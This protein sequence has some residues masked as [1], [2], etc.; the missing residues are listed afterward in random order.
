LEEKR[1]PNRWE[2]DAV[3]PDHPVFVP[4]GGHVC[5]VNSLPLDMANIS[6][7]TSDP[8]GGVIVKDP[9]T[10]EPTGVLFE[11]ARRHLIHPLLPRPTYE[12][13][14]EGIR[15]AMRALNEFGVTSVCEAG[16]YPMED[17]VRAYLEVSAGDEVTVRT[18]ILLRVEN[19]KNVTELSRYY[20]SGFGRDLLKSGGLKVRVDGGVEGAYMKEPYMVVPGLQED[21]E[22]RGCLMLVPGGEDEF[23]EILLSAARG[24]WKV[25]GHVV[26]DAGIEYYVDRCEEI[27]HEISIRDLRW[28][29]HHV[30]LPTNGS[31]EKMRELR[32]VATGQDHPTYLGWN[33][34]RLW[35]PE[36]AGYAVP[37]RKLLDSGIVIGGGTDAPVV[38][39]NPFLSIWW[40]VTRKTLTA[41]PDPLGPEQAITVKEALR[42]YTI[43]SAYCLN[44]ED[45]IGSIEVGKLAD[46]VVLDTDILT[47]PEDDIKNI[48]VLMTIIGGRIV[49]NK[50]DL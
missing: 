17:D 37:L 43:N 32:L 5:V 24:G 45:K 18:E 28:A 6:S 31:I 21:E 7:E 48:N 38:P 10:G 36:R 33:Q 44:W 42:V 3:A 46:F 4:R 27:D 29:A 23:R 16:I 9:E 13:K 2:L 47:C 20:S 40:M 35:G 8:P 15:S 30:F 26:G 12:S 19:A 1:L 34:I 14:V 22:Y 11:T 25:V 41:G 50:M 39:H 49:Y